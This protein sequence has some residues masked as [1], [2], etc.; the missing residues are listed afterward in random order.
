M[1]K[2][3][4]KG[5]SMSESVLQYAAER[6][7]ISFKTDAGFSLDHGVC[8]LGTSR[9]QLL[10]LPHREENK[11]AKQELHVRRLS[12]S[13]VEFWQSVRN[14]R[15]EPLDIAEIK[16]FDGVLELEGSGWRVAHSELF[17][18]ER[19]F[20]GYTCFTGGLL[21][22]IPGTDGDFGASENTPFPGI[23]FTHPE[24]GTVLMGT[25]SQERCKPHWKL[26]R[27]GR[28]TALTA[29]D[30]FTGVPHIPV[31][32]GQELETERWVVLSTP[33][34]LDEAVDEYFRLLRQRIR[35]MGADSVLRRAVLWG[36]WNYNERPRGQWDVTHDWV[37][38]NARALAKR[39]P[40]RP[41]FVMIDDGYQIDRSQWEAGSDYFAS[42]LE[43][44]HPDG[45]TPHDPK[46]FPRGM[47]GAA[48][49][50]R[51]AGADPAIWVTPR[52]HLQSPLAIARPDWLLKV[53]GNRKFGK[54]S[55]FLDYSLPEVREYTRGAWNTVCNEWGYKGVKLDFWT[56]PF[57]VPGVCFQNKE[58]TAIELRNQ[59]LRDLREFVPRDGYIIS[60]VVVNSGNPFLGE[61]V[62]ASRM[63]MDIGA[64]T[65]ANIQ[66]SAACVTASSPFY[67]HDCLLGDPDTI[68]WCQAST[69]DE[70]RLWAT[71]AL[72]SGG[73]FQV[74]GDLTRM[75]PEAD[76]MLRTAEGF[77]KPARRTLN[78]MGEAG[79]GNLP[80]S[81]LVL[82]RED[83]V[84][85]AHLNWMWC[86]RAV[87]LSAPARDLWTGKRLSGRCEIPPHGAIL[88]KR[89]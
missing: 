17:S 40:G 10:S 44:F 42:C 54:R 80:A 50:I 47:K 82:E 15:S 57:E 38:A 78:G 79:A 43:I 51:K 32:K 48:D 74:G 20:H 9:G 68:G 72:M 14:L 34:G 55:A 64:G 3:T 65:W 39:V 46:L 11:G 52:L 37:V 75:S 5:R 69:L 35:F 8:A 29:E 86:N 22:A 12:G 76:E 83:A 63:G 89:S 36:T 73:M 84:Y 60:C 13:A 19:Y 6:G 77:F 41:R 88:F 62:D 30:R 56:F 49:A 21:A 81:H 58:F 33:G 23:I 28:Q 24:R 70:N 1:E 2:Q 53:D 7:R 67:R 27:N 25:L 87:H 4:K 18:V 16:M 85:E 61:Y 66:Q 71:M 31:K 45:K 26:R 59:F